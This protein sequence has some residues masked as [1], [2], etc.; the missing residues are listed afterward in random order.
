MGNIS[1][2]IKKAVLSEDQKLLRGI[3]DGNDL[4]NAKITIVD[5]IMGSGKTTWAINEMKKSEGK[6]IYITPYLD[7]IK[8]VKNNLEGIRPLYEPTNNND[9][10]AKRYDFYKFVQKGVDIVSTHSLFSTC[11]REILEH[12]KLHDYTLILDE[13]MEVVKIMEL[14]KYDYD[15]LLE[16]ESICISEDGKVEWL[17]DNYSGSFDWIKNYAL[18]GQ[19]YKHYSQDTKKVAFFVWQFPAEVFKYF[20]EVCVLTYLFDSQIQKYYF[21]LHNLE[22]EYKQIEKIDGKYTLVDFDSENEYKQI[23]QFKEL[24]NVYEG[25][26]N[27]IGD[28]RYNLSVSYYKGNKRSK[29]LQ[30]LKKNTENYMQHIVK[31]KSEYNM[32]TTYKEEKDR[33][34]G[35]GYSKGFVSV[36]ARATNQFSNKK[37]LAYL[38]NRFLQPYVES[39][40]RDLGIE[41]NQEL[42]ALSELIQWIWRSAIRN[43]EQINIY[44]PSVRMRILLNQW[45]DCEQITKVI[46]V[47]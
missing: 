32:W 25:K 5:S 35:K 20:K 10:G 23:R 40:F 29:E 39:Y 8:R 7:E 30:Q 11:D 21:D 38:C 37:N 15:M 46:K 24:I 36:N 13:V 44:I 19:L 42:W 18:A 22:Y 4:N 41:I 1:F 34:K 2:I 45:L 31:G 14:S 17:N 26:L 28:G 47:A 9:F 6:Y 3:F 43:N 33:L 12:I 27:R 16:T